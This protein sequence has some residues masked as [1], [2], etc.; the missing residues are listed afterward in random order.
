MSRHDDLEAIR[1]LKYRYFRALD[2]KDWDA[3][4]STLAEDA[5]TS[6]DNGRYAFEGRAAIL[7]FLRGALGSPNMIS[8]H[9]G[10][11][12]EIELTGDSSARGTWYL[13]DMVIFREANTVLRGAAFYSDEYVRIDGEWKIRSTGYERTFEEIELRAAPLQIRT[14]FDAAG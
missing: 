6:Y 9:H 1:Q 8:M 13:E 2:C 11:H 10:H 3:L 5:T 14:R 4:A 7:E 12:P